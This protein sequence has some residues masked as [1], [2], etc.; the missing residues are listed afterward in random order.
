MVQS[1]VRM[2]F[3]D[4]LPP[5]QSMLEEVLAGL[6]KPQKELSPKFFY[7]A[8]GCELFD[9]ICGLPEYYPT[10]AELSIMRTYAGA[11]AQM[12][13][14]DCTL[15]EIGCGN[16]EK[17]RALLKE[18][19][20]A[21]FVAVDIAQAQLEASCNALVGEFPHMRV[22]AIRADFAHELNLPTAAL[23]SG[24]RVLY[25]PGSTIGNFTPAEARIFLSRWAPLLGAGG[26]ALIG[27]DLKK[28]P[29][30]LNAAY[31]DAQ[32]ITAQFN[33]NVLRNINR[34]LGADFDPGAFRHNARYS[35]E[36]GRIEM[37]LESTKAQRV[38]LAGHV[39]EF[40]AGETIHT[41][42]SCKYDIAEFQALARE[43]GFE[44]RASWTDDDRL[45][46][47]HYFTLP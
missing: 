26:G 16:S 43:A 32:G 38:T 29:A 41:E 19:E 22:V 42:N 15:I 28:D 27:V 31:N 34:E 14:G 30:V 45:F 1:S 24:R 9:A 7:D 21:A 8:R 2:S 18:L 46:S 23:G 6:A 35:A 39:L 3:H 17:T 12:C 47:V 5:Q 33:L 20:P 36:K 4:L 11:M 37:H 10:R 44:A 25:F 13:G 40:R